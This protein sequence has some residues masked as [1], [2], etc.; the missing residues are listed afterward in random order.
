MGGGGWG[1]KP[2]R[3]HMQ[4]KGYGYLIPMIKLIHSMAEIYVRIKI[5]KHPIEVQTIFL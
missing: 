4:G 2:Q 3:N 1:L 5:I